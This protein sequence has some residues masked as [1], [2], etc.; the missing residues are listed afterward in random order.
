MTARRQPPNDRSSASEHP[1]TTCGSVPPAKGR[2]E[3]LG[4]NSPARHPY[5]GLYCRP[6]R[7]SKRKIH[8]AAHTRPRLG[9]F[10]NAHLQKIAAA[11]KTL[12]VGLRM[13]AAIRSSLPS[14]PGAPSTASTTPPSWGVWL[15]QPQEP[16]VMR[17]GVIDNNPGVLR[18]VTNTLASN[19]MLK[20]CYQ[21]I[22][23]RLELVE[24][25]P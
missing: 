7:V 18:S 22:H 24:V 17:V 6:S 1:R 14:L 21:P 25:H 19:L 5:Q 4:S 23:H 2:M 13:F 10:T 16:Q 15:L 8:A 20:R 11:W 9:F 12:A 3:K